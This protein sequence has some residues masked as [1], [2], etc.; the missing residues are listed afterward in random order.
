M[1]HTGKSGDAK[2]SIELNAIDAATTQEPYIGHIGPNKNPLSAHFFSL[3]E[4]Y[5]DSHIQPRKL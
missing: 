2:K 3:A 4:Q 1:P 5:M